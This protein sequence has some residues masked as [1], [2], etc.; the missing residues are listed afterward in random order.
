MCLVTGPLSG[1]LRS[2]PVWDPEPLLCRRRPRPRDLRG[3][4]HCALIPLDRLRVFLFKVIYQSIHRIAVLGSLARKPSPQVGHGGGPQVP[5]ALR[6]PDVRRPK[7][8]SRSWKGSG[9]KTPGPPLNARE[10]VGG[11]EDCS[12]SRPH[13]RLPDPRAIP[14]SGAR[15]ALASVT[16]AGWLSRRPLVGPFLLYSVQTLPRR[17]QGTSWS[18]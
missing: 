8:A 18:C 4:R 5:S 7:W 13:P 14:P 11:A 16:V 3:L 17:G 1:E 6:C 15:V 10:R 2:P 12:R 9:S